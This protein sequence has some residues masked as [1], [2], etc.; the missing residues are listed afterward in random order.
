MV[1]V[2]VAAGDRVEAEQAAGRGR[3]RKAVVE[4]PSP[5]GGLVTEVHVKRGQEVAAATPWSAAGGAGALPPPPPSRRRLPAA[6]PDAASPFAA[7]GPPS[8]APLPPAPAPEPAPSAPPSPPRPRCAASR[9]RSAS[10]SPGWPAAA[11]AGR[12]P[13]RTSSA[14]RGSAPRSRH[15]CRPRPEALR[16]ARLL[17]LGRG[18][19]RADEQGPPGHRRAHAPAWRRHAPGHP[20][21][22]GRHH[23]AR[24][25]AQAA[26]RRGSSGRRQADPDRDPGQ[27]RGRRP[28]APSQAQRQRGHGQPGGGLQA[29]TSTSAWRSTPSTACWCR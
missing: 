7:P 10:T 19:S 21:R 28:Q 13:W 29:A 23:R 4:I 26:S 5:R 24:G 27:G 11:P 9:A 14:R 8:P 18:R 17:P 20:A 6:A 15:R 22:H 3:D 16:P 1:A 25:A 12:S 2:L